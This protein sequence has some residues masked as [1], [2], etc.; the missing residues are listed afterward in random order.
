MTAMNPNLSS[1]GD[2]AFIT[3]LMVECNEAMD[4]LGPFVDFCIE[5]ELEPIAPWYMFV[6]YLDNV[7]LTAQAP[8]LELPI[9]MD[10]MNG[11]S[12]NYLGGEEIP[13]QSMECFRSLYSRLYP[14]L[15][16]ISSYMHHHGHP[17]WLFDGYWEEPL[18]YH[19]P[20]LIV[21]GRSC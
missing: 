19:N 13:L 3:G 11:M 7:L 5:R 2:G 21:R 10:V 12:Q 14:H 9:H 15:L 1:R 20:V 8:P 17:L 6:H 4:A 16:T 18:L